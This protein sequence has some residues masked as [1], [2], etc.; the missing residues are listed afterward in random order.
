MWQLLLNV[1]DQVWQA[2]A[3]EVLATA[4]ERCCNQL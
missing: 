4:L 2:A 1:V 3:A